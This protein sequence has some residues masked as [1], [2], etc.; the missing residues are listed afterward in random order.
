MDEAGDLYYLECP[1]YSGVLTLTQIS[2]CKTDSSDFLQSTA[3]NQPFNPGIGQ[4]PRGDHQSDSQSGP[5]R[6]QVKLRL[7]GEA[8]PLLDQEG[9]R[10][11]Q[12]QGP[13][14][15]QEAEGAGVGA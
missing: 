15:L 2:R 10:S 3:L 1:F 9:H 7:F 5:D 12:G 11:G 13:I 14:I 6:K 8:Q 4:H